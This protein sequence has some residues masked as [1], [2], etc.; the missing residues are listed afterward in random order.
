MSECIIEFEY[1][2]Y[3]EHYRLTI[4]YL[5]QIFLMIITFR[6]TCAFEK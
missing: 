2:K 4:Q 5:I 3:L 6:Y 1:Y